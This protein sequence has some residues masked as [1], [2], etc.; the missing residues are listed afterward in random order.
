MVLALPLLLGVVL[1]VEDAADDTVIVA[2]PIGQAL[3]AYLQKVADNGASGTILVACQGA[4][5]LCKGYGQANKEEGTPCRPDT[6]YDIGSITKQFTAAAILKLEMAHKLAVTDSIDKYFRDVPADKKAITLHHL[7]TH[8][9][10]LID[11]LGD[12]YVVLERDDMIKQAMQSNLRWA[13]GTRYAYSNLGYSLLAAI[14]ELV[15]GDAYEEF[16]EQNLFAPAGMKHT[17]YRLPSWDPKS[18]AVGYQQGSRW[19][20]PLDHLWAEDGPYWNLR[21]NGGILSTARDMYRWHLALAGEEILSREAKNELFKPHV[22]EDDSG[23]SHY[24]YG[25]SIQPTDRGTRLIWHNGGNGVF[26]ADFWRYVDEDIV[27]FLAT[28]E[29]DRSRQRVTAELARIAREKR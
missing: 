5:V 14:V 26:F 2:G 15:S 13:P 25:W 21:G 11:V 23:R 8:S 4:L 22:A 6:V 1:A 20:T 7:L 16:L 27:I 18:L 29:A 17:G 12:D 19:G 3:D 9:A 24:G 28:A 10:G